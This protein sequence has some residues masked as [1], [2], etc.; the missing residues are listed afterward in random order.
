MAAGL[1]LQTTMI[2]LVFVVNSVQ[3]TCCN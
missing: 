2:R 1:E 3:I